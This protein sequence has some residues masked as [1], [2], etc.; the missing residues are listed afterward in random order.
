MPKLT[1]TL[2]R[3]L[4]IVGI[5]A[6]GVIV[7][8]LLKALRKPPAKK[9]S[10]ILA[11]LLKAY[12]VNVQDI[13]MVVRG[14]G[15][16]EPKVQVQVVPQVSG[17]V[18]NCHNDFVNGGFFKAH[19]PLITIDQ[20]DY[21]LAVENAEAAVAADRVYLDRELAEADVARQPRQ[22]PSSRPQ[23]QDWPR[24]N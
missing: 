11:P 5:L 16:V 18:D 23:R 21:K 15:T 24:L 19:E 8:V 14:Y 4:L 7:L 1:D 9:E 12:V 17:R 22:R 13:Q 3:I 20:R 2:K 6:A 10:Q